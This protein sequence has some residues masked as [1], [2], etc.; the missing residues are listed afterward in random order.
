MSYTN[1]F[2]S[3]LATLNLFVYWLW[4][5][6][7]STVNLT[8]LNTWNTLFLHY[9]LLHWLSIEFPQNPILT[10]VIVW[11]SHNN[12]Y[13]D[14]M[15]LGRELRWSIGFD[16]IWFFLNLP[17]IV[18]SRRTDTF[19]FKIFSIIYHTISACR[20]WKLSHQREKSEQALLKLLAFRA[21]GGWLKKLL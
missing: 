4:S 16:R 19:P 21:S 5:H 7:F 18:I 2:H 15:W 14:S 8:L 6:E 17:V 12:D 3:V 9:L 13:G 10:V 1:Y 11:F 20:N